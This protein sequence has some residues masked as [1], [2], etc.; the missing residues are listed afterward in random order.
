MSEIFVISLTWIDNLYIKNNNIYFKYVIIMNKIK[1]QIILI[2]FLLLVTNSDSRFRSQ[3]LRVMSAARFPCAKSLKNCVVL[4]L[5]V[6]Y[7]RRS[8]PELYGI[9]RNWFR[10]SDLRLIVHCCLLLKTYIRSNTMSKIKIKM[11]IG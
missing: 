8:S 2:D 4:L 9:Y 7:L 10:S 6:S 5:L 1:F 3:D 11:Y